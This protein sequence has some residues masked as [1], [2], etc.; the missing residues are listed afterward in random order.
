MAAQPIFP[1]LWRWRVGGPA[2][3]DVGEIDL[4][5]ISKLLNIS[6]ENAKK[7]LQ[8]ARTALRKNLE[9]YHE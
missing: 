7:R 3:F 6:Y 1:G 5:D 8:R 9:A 2:L 4:F